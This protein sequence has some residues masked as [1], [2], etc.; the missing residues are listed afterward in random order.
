MCTDLHDFTMSVL[1]HACKKL[2]ICL[3]GE[4]KVLFRLPFKIYI[5]LF[6]F[7]DTRKLVLIYFKII[8]NNLLYDLK[9]KSAYN[10]QIYLDDNNTDYNSISIFSLNVLKTQQLSYPITDMKLCIYKT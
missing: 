6:N 10:C 8:L 4:V 2:H 9:N 3:G 1:F 7:Q 5:I